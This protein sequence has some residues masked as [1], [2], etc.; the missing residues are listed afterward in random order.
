MF[1]CN[2]TL[3]RVR[4]VRRQVARQGIKAARNSV[5]LVIAR[6]GKVQGWKS[7]AHAR[8]KDPQIDY[9]ES[10]GRFFGKSIV[11]RCAGINRLQGLLKIGRI[12]MWGGVG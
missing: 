9:R 1:K 12:T 11:G 6:F 3:E 7:G 5:W 10:N 2:K 8:S 4:H